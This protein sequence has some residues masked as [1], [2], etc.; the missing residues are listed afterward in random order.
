MMSMDS[1]KV[2]YVSRN[3]SL[4]VYLVWSQTHRVFNVMSM[5]NYKVACALCENL[6]WLYV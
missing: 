1:Y 3:L 6:V 4:V 2:V 5:D